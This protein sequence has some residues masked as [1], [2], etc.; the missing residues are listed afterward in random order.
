MHP[1]AWLRIPETTRLSRR[2]DLA[3]FALGCLGLAFLLAQLV[4]YPHGRDQAIFGVVAA[5]SLEGGTPYADA[6]DFKPPGIYVLYGIAQ[7]LF[8]KGQV[9]IRLLEAASIVTMIGAFALLSKRFAGGIGPGLVGG[10]V[11]TLGWVELEFWNTAQPESFAASLLAWALVAATY[12]SEVQSRQHLAQILAGA[13]YAAAALQK[14][15]LGV[16]IAISWLVSFSAAKPRTWASA[17]SYAAGFILPLGMTA[18]WLVSKEAWDDFYQTLFEWI[19]GYTNISTHDSALP[20]R[21]FKAVY[22]WLVGFSPFHLPGLMLWVA[23]PRLAPPESKCAYH[24]LA[25]LA[26]IL[27]GIAYQGKFFEYH[28][29]TVIPLAGL[30][31]GWGYWKA[32]IRLRT[33]PLGLL[34]ATGISLAILLGAVPTRNNGPAAYW[35]RC[36]VR[37]TLWADPTGT[38]DL[39]DRLYSNAESPAGPRRKVAAWLSKNTSP[40]SKVFVWGFEPGIYQQSDRTPASR[41][42]YNVAQRVGW[43][44]AIHRARLLEDLRINQPAAIVIQTGDRLPWVTGNPRDSHEELAHFQELQQWLAMHYESAITIDNL[45]IWVPRN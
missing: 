30:L 42:I 36:G 23:L 34:F 7:M 20:S 2:A 41:Y 39:R 35:H 4:D 44:T 32:W 16:G 15:H 8:G 9:A 43:D 1:S 11:A 5:T 10:L 27:F 37:A 31:A 12:R 26:P 21:I 14:P 38:Q 25:I 18:A 13:L 22:L 19:P 24:L 29:G 28:F 17:V 45:E 33:T 40:Q 6:W 3:L